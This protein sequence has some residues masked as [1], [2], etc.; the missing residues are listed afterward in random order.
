[1]GDGG[2]LCRCGGGEMEVCCVGEG[3]GRWRGAV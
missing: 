1:M 3:D 2:E